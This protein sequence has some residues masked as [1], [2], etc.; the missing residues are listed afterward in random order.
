M[1]SKIVK[2]TVANNYGTEAIYPANEPAF[3]FA[4]IAGTK[5]LTRTTIELVKK[6]GYEVKVEQEVVSL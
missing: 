2:V 6:L 3:L 5:T 4:R 1:N